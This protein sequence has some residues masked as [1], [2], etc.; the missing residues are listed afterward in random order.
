MT[1][2][3]GRREL[4]AALGGAAAAWP[5]AVRAQQ[6]AMP[7]IGYLDA[8]SAAERTRQVAAF[9][10][11]LG[12][13]GYQEGQNVALELRWAEGQYGRFGELAA[14]LVR[15]RVSVIATPGGAAAALAAKSATA[16]RA[17]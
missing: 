15:R 13:A 11:G 2:T 5:L 17:G 3:I 8:G 9:R 14:D 7:V 6:P 16:T 1:V 12:E 10:K 4:L